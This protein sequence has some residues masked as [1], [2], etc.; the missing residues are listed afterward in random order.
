MAACFLDALSL[1]QQGARGSPTDSAVAVR[2]QLPGQQWLL[3]HPEEGLELSRLPVL[4]H[5]HHL[6]VVRVTTL[7]EE[8]LVNTHMDT[9]ITAVDYTNTLQIDHHD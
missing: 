5:L 1:T 7:G 6:H 9:E 2:L 3:P 4:M 8:R